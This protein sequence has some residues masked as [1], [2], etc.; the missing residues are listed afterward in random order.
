MSVFFFKQK[1]AYEMR[2]SDWSSDVCS[3]DLTFLSPKQ[4]LGRK[5]REALIAFWLPSG[6]RVLSRGDGCSTSTMTPRSKGISREREHCPSVLAGGR[7]LRRQSH[8]ALRP[9]PAEIG[10]AS[11]RERVCQYV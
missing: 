4:T 9:G 5:A 10:R 2:I 3:S 8:D 11:W 7:D 1:T 6:G